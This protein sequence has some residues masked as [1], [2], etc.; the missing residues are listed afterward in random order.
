MCV[1]IQYIY[2]H[3]FSWRNNFYVSFNIIRFALLEGAILVRYARVPPR[4]C[5]NKN[6]RMLSGEVEKKE[7]MCVV[8]AGNVAFLKL[9]Y[10]RMI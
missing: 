3:A 5:R 10:N 9:H 4:L 8:G 6:F 7:I 1:Y 2:R